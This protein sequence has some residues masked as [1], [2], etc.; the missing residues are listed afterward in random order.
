MK[1]D[2]ARADDGQAQDRDGHLD[3]QVISHG[4]TT[5][6][7]TQRGN[8]PPSGSLRGTHFS[9]RVAQAHPSRPWVRVVQ[10]RPSLLGVRESRPPLDS[11]WD[12]AGR[13]CPPPP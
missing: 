10:A 1:Y 5:A 8:R 11:L 12:R 7:G 4:W 6:P 3:V 9:V 13:T 2:P